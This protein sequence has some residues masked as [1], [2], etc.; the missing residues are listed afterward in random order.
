MQVIHRISI[1]SSP[2]VRRELAKLGVVVGAAGLITTFEVSEEHESWPKVERWIVERR[3]ADIV[4]T[5]FTNQ[6]IATAEWLELTSEWHHGYPQPREDAFGYL[7][8]T[9]DLSEYCRAC[10]TGLRQKAP[11]QMKA[12][13][14]WGR[15]GIL[16]L[17]WVFDEYFVT[18][19]VWAT[20][21]APH[22]IGFRPVL[23]TKKASELKT[24]VQ[25]DIREEVGIVTD[26]LITDAACLRCR[27][28]KYLPSVR[29]FFPA[30]HTAPAGH[31]ARTREEFGSG[32]AASR[33]IVISKK[34]ADALAERK[35][36]GTSVRPVEPLP[37]L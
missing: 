36:R 30:L 26:G 12:E 11:F 15:N 5:R 35:I 10:G 3:A 18:P 13:P 23:D 21:F 4:S 29:G 19:E 17:N 27:R 20:I 6:E 28:G 7:E 32:K 1:S 31:V 2:D 25:L 9:Y 24:A 8:A 22:G 14:K 16:Q 34:L 37:T 33:R